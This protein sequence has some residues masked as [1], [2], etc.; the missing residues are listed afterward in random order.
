MSYDLSNM[1]IFGPF[2][3]AIDKDDSR[4]KM[5]EDNVKYMKFYVNLKEERNL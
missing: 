1:T 5:P 3:G 2:L 4:L